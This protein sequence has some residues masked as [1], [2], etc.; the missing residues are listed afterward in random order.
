MSENNEVCTDEEKKPCKCKAC[1]AVIS[2]LTLVFA[3]T[4]MVYAILLNHKMN[5]LF[6]A[7]NIETS[8]PKK[9]EGLISETYDR[10]QS[11]AKA[12]KENKPILVFFYA[13]WCGYC[14]RFA[15]IYDKLS[16]DKAIK[17]KLAIAYVNCEDPEN[18]EL[19]QE[20][21]IEGF[22]SVFVVKGD[23][24]EQIPNNLLYDDEKQLKKLL[25][26]KAE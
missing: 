21:E 9:A 11:F 23:K 12:Q 14:Q 7:A 10:G 18:S 16:K 26:E 4:S 15:P 25:I 6:K 8:A 20:Y 22:P 1:K 19:V 17:D 3:L 24:K 5:V 2:L 13:N